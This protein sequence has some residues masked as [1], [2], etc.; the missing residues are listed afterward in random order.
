MARR[1]GVS[2]DDVVAAAMRVCDQ[3][4]LGDLTVAAVAA[5]VGCRPPS[6]YHHVDGLAGLVRAVTFVAAEQL[7]ATLESAAKGIEDP[8]AAMAAAAHDWGVRHPARFDALRRAVDADADPELAAARS[9]VLLPVQDAL[10]GLGVPASDRATLL[11]ALVAAVRGCIAA[12]LDAGTNLDPAMAESRATGR[13][14]LLRL[15]LD[16]VAEVGAAA[17]SGERAAATG[18]D[19]AVARPDDAAQANT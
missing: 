12:D 1:L 2:R 15:V 11:A 14:L 19:H 5:E 13:Q 3:R 18:T 17:R 6:V 7:L 8:L 16:H 9:Q 10:V 4:G